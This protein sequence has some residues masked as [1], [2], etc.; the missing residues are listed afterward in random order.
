M[1]MTVGAF[2]YRGYLILVAKCLVD[3]DFSC[4]AKRLCLGVAP[5]NFEDVEDRHG[6]MLWPFLPD[7]DAAVNEICVK[8]D[9]EG[10]CDGG[11]VGGGPVCV[12]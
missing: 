11:E 1:S 8:I 4:V 10:L 2:R 12:W 6:V 9:F 3:G 7:P 5:E